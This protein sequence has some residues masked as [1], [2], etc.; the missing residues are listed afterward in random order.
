MY[1]INIVCSHTAGVLHIRPF[2]PNRQLIS[3][4]PLVKNVSR[5]GTHIVVMIPS[6]PSKS[7][8]TSLQVQQRYNGTRG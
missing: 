2:Y 8:N 5:H 3:F 1:N 4:N 6:I 7:G